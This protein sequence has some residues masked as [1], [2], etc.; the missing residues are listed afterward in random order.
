MVVGRWVEIQSFQLSLPGAG[1]TGNLGS[2]P[3]SG[4]FPQRKAWQPTPVFLPGESH[5]QRSLEGY[6]PQ[7]H[8]EL[9]TTERRHTPRDHGNRNSLEPTLWPGPRASV[10]ENL[11][12]QRPRC[13]SRAGHRVAA[14]CPA[15]GIAS[16]GGSPQIPAGSQKGKEA[17]HS[18]TRP[19]HRRQPRYRPGVAGGHWRAPEGGRSAL[20]GC[21][22]ERRPQGPATSSR[23]RRKR[24]RR[25]VKTSRLSACPLQ[26]APRAK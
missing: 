9:D 10:A 24:E 16:P 15:P 17:L 5:G 26:Q 19:E 3:G 14:P 4:R 7:G 22:Q 1:A 20:P 25:G 21:G 18:S 23:Q 11:A 13:S 12:P 8:T 2:I 6:S